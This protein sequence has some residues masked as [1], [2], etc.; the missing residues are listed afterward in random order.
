VGDGEPAAFTDVILGGRYVSPSHFADED[1]VAIE[2]IGD[3]SAA[4]LALH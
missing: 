3:G 1:L 2:F 4:Y